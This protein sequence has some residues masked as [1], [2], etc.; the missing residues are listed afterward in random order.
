MNAYEKGLIDFA[1]LALN[2]LEDHHDWDADTI[3]EIST[4]AIR[5]GVA[6]TDAH[7]MFV[8]TNKLLTVSPMGFDDSDP[9]ERAARRA[10]T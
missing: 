8:R 6:E 4:A 2:V 1:K 5:L 9:I 10:R 3:D 7:F